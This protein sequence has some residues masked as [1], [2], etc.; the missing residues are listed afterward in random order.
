M[1]EIAEPVVAELAAN[2]STHGRLRGRDF[3]LS[4]FTTP[5]D[6]A[7]RIEVT[8]IR[9]DRLPTPAPQP[10][11]ARRPPPTKSPAEACC[12]SRRCPT[13]GAW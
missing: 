9:G 7:L 3:L 8:D 6:R 1:T 5:G 11:A 12:W 13:A 10:P 4:L 2:A